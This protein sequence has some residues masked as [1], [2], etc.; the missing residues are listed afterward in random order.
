[1]PVAPEEVEFLTYDEDKLGVWSAFHLA[2][3]YK[4]HTARGSQEN[5]T[6]RIEHQTLD[7]TIEKNANLVG[8]AATTVVARADGVRVI[9]LNL[10]GTLRV[11][12]VVTDSGQPLSFIQED[13]KEDPDF[14]VILPKALA[15]GEKVTLTTKYSGKD[16]VSNEGGGNYYPIARM[17]WYP[18]SPTMSLGEF[19]DYDLTFRIP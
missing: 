17:D 19:S 9:P 8:K 18:N 11:Q 2:E 7:M 13:K 15:A 1:M 14:Y 12:N 4:N 16:A 5:A 6:I 10:F 3:E